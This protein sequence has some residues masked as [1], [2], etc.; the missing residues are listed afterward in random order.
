MSVIDGLIYDEE[1]LVVFNAKDVQ[2]ECLM[3]AGSISEFWRN[4]DALLYDLIQPGERILFVDATG[5]EYPCHY[6]SCSTMEFF[7]DSGV[8]W[9]FILTLR[10]V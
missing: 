8:W 7:R 5:V 2:L 1:G 6:K 10:F 4:Y 9:R 3:K